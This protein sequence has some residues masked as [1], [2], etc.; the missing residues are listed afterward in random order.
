[1]LVKHLIKLLYNSNDISFQH[2]FNA[3]HQIIEEYKR[4]NNYKF[5]LLPVSQLIEI[6]CFCLIVCS[7]KA[8]F[9]FNLENRADLFFFFFFFQMKNRAY[10]FK[11]LASYWNNSSLKEFVP[12]TAW[13]CVQLLQPGT[14]CTSTFDNLQLH[15]TVIPESSQLN[16]NGNVK[17]L[18]GPKSV[19]FP[20]PSLLAYKS[21]TKLCDENFN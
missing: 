17:A 10:L 16:S 4:M 5:V 6:R 20:T 12:T 9:Y 19:I 8:E 14:N 21:T 2:R 7:H 3:C 18:Y 11:L 1:M 15:F 13:T